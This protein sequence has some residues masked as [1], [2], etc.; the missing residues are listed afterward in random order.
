MSETAS[1]TFSEFPIER[2]TNTG[3]ELWLLMPTNETEA[4]VKWPSSEFNPEG[5]NWRHRELVITK[6]RSG[7]DY[8]NLCA[9]LTEEEATTL[10]VQEPSEQATLT[11]RISGLN[12][13]TNVSVVARLKDGLCDPDNTQPIRPDGRALYSIQ[14][15]KFGVSVNRFFYVCTMKLVPGNSRLVN[16]Q[17]DKVSLVR[18]KEDP[19]KV[20]LNIQDYFGMEKATP[21]QILEALAK[22][23]KPIF[24]TILTTVFGRFA[25]KVA[26]AIKTAIATREKVSLPSASSTPNKLGMAEQLAALRN[27][28]K[29]PSETA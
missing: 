16:V 18:P 10:S 13:D 9:D 28:G 12:D 5:K 17:I 2:S 4:T 27:T 6:T 1:G 24:V 8:V 20:Y 23:N 22:D 15:H 3:L 26:H 29:L 14:Q 25:P 7:P 21:P 11:V 19:L